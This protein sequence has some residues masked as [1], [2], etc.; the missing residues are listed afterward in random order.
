MPNR[1]DRLYGIDESLVEVAVEMRRFIGV[2]GIAC[3]A[4]GLLLSLPGCGSDREGAILDLQHA[5]RTY[6]YAAKRIAQLEKIFE[7]PAVSP[8]TI[9]ASAEAIEKNVKQSRMFLTSAIYSYQKLSSINDAQEYITY[10][11][12]MVRVIALDLEAT[13]AAGD[14]LK[15]LQAASNGGSATTPSA[16]PADTVKEKSAYITKKFQTADRLLKA[17]REFKVKNGLLEEKG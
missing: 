15:S 3:L 4:A 7:D 2:L 10:K 14:T 6:G 1:S 5:E 16:S 17:A 11:D 8:E 9:L 13:D 12:M